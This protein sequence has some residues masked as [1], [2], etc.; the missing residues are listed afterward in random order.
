MK[1]KQIKQFEVGRV[2]KQNNLNN[3]QFDVVSNEG[4]RFWEF[5]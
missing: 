2:L 3:K 1:Q 5:V 4:K